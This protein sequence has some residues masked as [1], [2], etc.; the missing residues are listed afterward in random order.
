MSRAKRKAERSAFD[1]AQAARQVAHTRAMAKL[2]YVERA[3]IRSAKKRGLKKFVG[4][5]FGWRAGRS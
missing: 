5:N 1:R 3:Q 4:A 2:G